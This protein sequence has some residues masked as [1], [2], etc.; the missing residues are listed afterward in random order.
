MACS[1]DNAVFPK[2]F[3]AGSSF[4]LTRI[5]KLSEPNRKHRAKNSGGKKYSVLSCFS[6]LPDSYVVS[7][8]NVW[9]GSQHPANMSSVL[10]HA[11]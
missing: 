1:A 8:S 9:F 2:C 6:V 4:L 11:S 5:I 10:K 3:S 7:I